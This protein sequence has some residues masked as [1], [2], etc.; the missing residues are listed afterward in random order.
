MSGASS[1]PLTVAEW[2][3]MKIVWSHKECAARDAYV[4]ASREHGWTPSTTKT[5]LRR[6]AEKGCLT[7]RAVGNSF[8]YRPSERVVP[9]L[10]G[11]AETLMDQ[12]LEGTT[13]LVL[14]HMVK[15]SR[16][17]ARELAELRALLDAHPRDEEAR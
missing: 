1:E 16:L 6:L 5:L 10:L 4:H 8:L 17:S 3:V 9:S 14:A 11:A 13:G 2:K 7:T 15:N 12:V